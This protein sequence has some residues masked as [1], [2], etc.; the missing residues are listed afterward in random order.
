MIE[1]AL[2]DNCFY[3]D[4]G[5]SKHYPPKNIKWNRSANVD[6]IDTV[7]F[8]DYLLDQVM[9]PMWKNKTKIA[10]LIEPYAINPHSYSAILDN[11]H[12]FDLVLTHHQDLLQKIPN[13]QFYPSAMTWIDEKDWQEYPKSHD[14]SIFASNKKITIG[15][16]LR[17]QVIA[18]LKNKKIMDI[19]GYGYNPLE[20]KLD[21]LSSYRFSLAIENCAVN[22][23]FTE[24]LID[25]FATYTI[26]IYWGCPEIQKFFNPDGMIICNTMPE[27][28]KSTN[29]ISADAKRIY[30][31]KYKALEENHK[32]AKE[33]YTNAEDW[34]FK[35]ILTKR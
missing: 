32:I 1:I 10:W 30:E 27:L 11:H 16:Q 26:P 24:K 25:C 6:H 33:H 9:H 13:G 14:I 29:T 21:G 15:H 2:Q 22:H 34:I 8:T 7:F 20:Y 3:G 4:L 17:H 19:F 31:D 5:C 12:F 28:I 18:V 23:Y 35:Q